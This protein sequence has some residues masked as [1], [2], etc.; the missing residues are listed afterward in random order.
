MY[1]PGRNQKIERTPKGRSRWPDGEWTALPSRQTFLVPLVLP[2]KA[3]RR[4]GEAQIREMVFDRIPLPAESAKVWLLI[5]RPG[6]FSRGRRTVWAAVAP[7]A[8][9]SDG[10]DRCVP[11]DLLLTTLVWDK[12]FRHGG[13]IAL[14]AAAGVTLIGVPPGG[15]PALVWKAILS[16]GPGAVEIPTGIASMLG[17]KST[18]LRLN[19]G[20]SIEPVLAKYGTVVTQDAMETLMDCVPALIA[21]KHATLSPGIAPHPSQPASIHLPAG[22]ETGRP[23]W[24]ILRAALLAISLL[25]PLAGLGLAKVRMT[26]LADQLQGRMLDGYEARF[27]VKVPDSLR[28][29]PLLALQDKA[30]FAAPARAAT[31]VPLHAWLAVVDRVS[32]QAAAATLRLDA[33]SLDIVRVEIRGTAADPQAVAQ[34]VAT[35][36][37]DPAL[38]DAAL[39]S[40]ETRM[41]DKRT[42]FKVRARLKPAAGHAAS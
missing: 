8:A 4:I 7:A 13:L 38:A 26:R 18:L 1:F 34:W 25:M 28:V 5:P 42:A 33:I 41:S 9:A 27:G 40:S 30:R 24:K 6:F 23:G 22:L 14:D 35:L 36:S 39:V 17:R 31:S 11:E 3:L 20:G 16:G 21:G 29:N 10:A 37:A 2:V 15:K 12:R 32:S 19:A